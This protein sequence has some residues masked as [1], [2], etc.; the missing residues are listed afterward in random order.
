LT[1]APGGGIL[2]V[3]PS[4]SGTEVTLMNLGSLT[5]KAKELFTRR[6]GTEAAKEDAQEIKDIARSD[7]S[8]G[9]KA[10]EGFEAIKDPGA[11]GEERRPGGEEPRPSGEERRPGGEEPRP[12]GEERRPGGEE[13][14]PRP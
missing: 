14:R 12:S 8:L 2:E 7:A 11:P 10:K 9:D 3:D 1:A 5:S 4:T 6:G 13:P